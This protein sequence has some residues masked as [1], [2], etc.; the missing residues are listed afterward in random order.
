MHLNRCLE[1]LVTA[2][3]VRSPF[4][5]L[6]ALDIYDGPVSGVAF[7]ADGSEALFRLQAWDDHQRTRVYAMSSVGRGAASAVLEIVSQYEKPRWPEWWIAQRA[8]DERRRESLA[9]AIQ[10]LWSAATAPSY[11]VVSNAL[12]ETIDLGARVD[13]GDQLS[14]HMG[15][16]PLGEPPLESQP[17]QHW[18][19]AIRAAAARR[20]T[21]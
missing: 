20:R 11:L 3:P 12:L 8:P 14:V 16:E 21:D 6:V 7:C 1:Q 17:I 18:V 10:S 13:P 19:E 5:R 4:D 9:N 15:R 2:R